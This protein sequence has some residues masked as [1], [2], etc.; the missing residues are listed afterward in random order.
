MYF[1]KFK[2]D[3]YPTCQIITVKLSNIIDIIKKI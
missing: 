2:D 1:K 3:L